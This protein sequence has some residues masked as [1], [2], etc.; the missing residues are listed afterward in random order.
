MVDVFTSAFSRL[1][2]IDG[3]AGP[4]NAPAYQGL[5]KAGTP[6]YPQGSV[7][8]IR[9][10]DPDALGAFKRVGRVRGAPDDPQLPVTGRY[11]L[12]T[13][14]LLRLVRQGC[15]VDLQV[16]MGTCQDPRDFTY[17]WDKILVLEGGTPDQWSTDGDLGA[18]GP[19]EQNTV[20]EQT[21]FFGLDLY[22]ITKQRIASIAQPTLV[23]NV[24]D[25]I[26]CDRISC[27]SCGIPSNGCDKIFAI[28]AL[29][30]GSPSGPPQVIYSADGGAT[31]GVSLVNS[32]NTAE[33]A[34]A[35][36]CV[37]SNI[38][39]LSSVSLSLHYASLASLLAGTA[40]W[41]E[42]GTGFITNGPAAL[43][44]QGPAN[45][46]IVGAAGYIYYSSNVESGV[47]VQSAGGATVQNLTAVHSYDALNVVAVG[48]SNAVVRTADGGITWSSIV[49]PAVGV[50]LN[51]VAMHGVD[52]WYVGTA[53]G[54]LYYT[55]NGGSTWTEVGFS[56]SGAG[57]VK[58]IAFASPTVGYMVHNTAAGL[59]RLFRTI[60]GGHS[61]Y[62]ASEARVT[63]PTNT[64]LNTVAVC[65]N[66]NVAFAAGANV[67]DGHMIKAS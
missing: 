10:P 31:W 29:P 15:E 60:D 39:V 63:Q 56:G 17:G 46:W 53:G 37:G 3:K 59:G 44:S 8:T 26:V 33:P 18:L 58:D 64:G 54:R 51:A 42:V 27:G 41:T 67:A 36:G 30:T 6:T 24:V 22:E 52:E 66:V 1:W 7:T 35:I 62:V 19:D 2:L 40:T 28:Q 20:N 9:I 47:V 14:N 45:V 25:M 11:G 50:A 61:W 55:R 16:H 49:G 48:A 23:S 32:L 4:A 5:I 12:E 57:A 13:S 38:V 65:S 43:T 34:L 21:T